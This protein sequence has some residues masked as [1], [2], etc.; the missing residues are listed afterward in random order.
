[1]IHSKELR[2][3]AIANANP[4]FG[5]YPFKTRFLKRFALRDGYDLQRV[6]KM[7]WKCDGSGMYTAHEEC[8]SC[9][10]SGIHHTNEHWLE[11]W[12]LQGTVYH[13]PRDHGEVYHENGRKYPEPKNEIYGIIQKG[14]E[15]VVI[16]ADYEGRE[17]VV[18][19]SQEAHWA[20][21]RLLVRYEP[22]TFWEYVKSCIRQKSSAWRIK[23]HFCLMRIRNKL[24]LFPIVGDDDIPF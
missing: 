6:N 19:S 1:M 23:R 2:W 13:V 12:N 5:F 3:F 15:C 7:C 17:R 10:G 14:I 4:Q 18:P 11:R 20:F 9:G 24:D 8:R 22:L 21:I 16:G